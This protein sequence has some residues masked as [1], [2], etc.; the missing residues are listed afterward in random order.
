M[1]DQDLV[2]F[3]PCIMLRDPR[4][5]D[6]GGTVP[7]LRAVFRVPY[8]YIYIY[9]YIWGGHI[10]TAFRNF[11]I[12][13]TTRSQVFCALVALSFSMYNFTLMFDITI[14]KNN[15]TRMISCGFVVIKR[16]RSEGEMIILSEI[17][18]QS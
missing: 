14:V 2:L 13:L 7:I 17:L 6:F 15:I 4:H 11:W 8:I 16:R 3:F 10:C 12:A 18:A 9:I 1:Y 5:P